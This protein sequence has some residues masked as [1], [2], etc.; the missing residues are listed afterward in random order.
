MNFAESLKNVYRKNIQ[1]YQKKKEIE[2]S[3][4]AIYIVGTLFIL[5][6]I[7]ATCLLLSG[8]K[9]GGGLVNMGK[10]ELKT[11]ISDIG[12]DVMKNI[13]SSTITGVNIP[14]IVGIGSMTAVISI[15]EK[16]DSPFVQIQEM[17]L[18]K[19]ENIPDKTRITKIKEYRNNTGNITRKDTDIYEPTEKPTTADKWSWL[20]TLIIIN[21]VV[22]LYIIALIIATSIKEK[23]GG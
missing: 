21:T 23:K 6:T 16:Y 4:L 8:C 10:P 18:Y 3:A 20:N 22:N 11:T 17:T 15:L 7:L 2:V 12:M 19:K 1:K 13:S 14:E 5:L 9:K